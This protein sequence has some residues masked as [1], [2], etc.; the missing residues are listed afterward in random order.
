MPIPK[1]LEICQSCLFDDLDTMRKNNV[2][3]IIQER[4]IRIRDL[5]TFWLQYPAKRD[6]EIV[7][8]LISR[9]KIQKSAAYD[10]VSIIRTLLGNINKASKDFHRWRFNEM[11]MESYNM[12]KRRKDTR[13]MVAA[14]DKYAKYNTL[15]KEDELS[16][17]FDVILVQPFE[18]TSDPSVIGITPVP[19]IKE[20]IS[21]MLKKYWTEDIEDITYEEADF[22]EESLFNPQFNNDPEE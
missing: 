10:D 3:V 6:K 11:I 8:E 14:S 21:V 1:T 5:Y 15:D 9:Y 16:N 17:Q 4:I 12:A 18:P 7:D 19:N 20:K 13:S 22:D 2:P